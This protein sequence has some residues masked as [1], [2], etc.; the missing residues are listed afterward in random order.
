M[1]PAEVGFHH[2]ALPSKPRVFASSPAAAS[3]LASTPWI[4]WDPMAA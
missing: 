1:R 4:S 3:A 2:R